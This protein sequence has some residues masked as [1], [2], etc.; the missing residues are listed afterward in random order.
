[1]AGGAGVF[2][3]WEFYAPLAGADEDISS[4]LPKVAVLVDEPADIKR[5]LEAWWSR[6]EEA[7][8]RSG[9]GNLAL[10]QELYFT[11]DE[12]LQRMD[13]LPSLGLEFLGM[14]S[15]GQE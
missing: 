11:P 3:G 5:T 4:L 10:P 8:E 15:E 7:H 2:P 6:V 12:W 14:S 9:V 1:R 13:G